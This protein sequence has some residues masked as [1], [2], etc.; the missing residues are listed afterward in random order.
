MSPTVT[1][2]GWIGRA[3]I[4]TVIYGPGELAYAHAVNESTDIQELLDYTQIMIAFIADWC[5]R[6]KEH[7]DTE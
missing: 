1:D 7:T 6:E 5:N 3:G 2:A 4:P